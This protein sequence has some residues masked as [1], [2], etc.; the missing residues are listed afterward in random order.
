MNLLLNSHALSPAPL[1]LRLILAAIVSL[2]SL[3]RGRCRP[4]VPVYF[5]SFRSWP[6]YLLNLIQFG[7][8][9]ADGG[10]ALMTHRF[11]TCFLKR[12]S[13]HL[14]SSFPPPRLI[15]SRQPRRSAPAPSLVSVS[16]L[17]FFTLHIYGHLLSLCLALVPILLVLNTNCSATSHLFPVPP[18]RR[19]R[20]RP[21]SHN[22][23]DCNPR[24][25]SPPRLRSGPRLAAFRKARARLHKRLGGGVDVCVW[26]GGAK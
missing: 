9:P 18:S 16:S 23:A 26:G 5:P 2:G 11:A 19:Q 21:P 10:F 13:S 3:A 4:P 8:S 1:S 24:K 7:C 22:R 15:Q 25:G 12:L 6:L 14:S 20:P 17:K